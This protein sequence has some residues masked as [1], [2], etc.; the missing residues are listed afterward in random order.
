MRTTIK[1]G[2]MAVASAL[3]LA[4]LRNRLPIAHLLIDAGANVSAHEGHALSMA[5]DNAHYEIAELLLEHGAIANTHVLEKAIERGH[6][7]LV[8]LLVEKGPPE[9]RRWL[10]AWLEFTPRAIHPNV[11]QYLDDWLEKQAQAEP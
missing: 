8:P 9:W 5:V 11:R 1:I 7:R 10:K 3:A 6:P 2:A 4:A